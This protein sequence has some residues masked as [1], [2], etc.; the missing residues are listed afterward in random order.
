MKKIT[1]FLILTHIF[2]SPTYGGID[3]E[4]KEEGQEKIKTTTLKIKYQSN[5]KFVIQEGTRTYTTDSVQPSLDK[6]GY[7]INKNQNGKYILGVGNGLLSVHE[8]IKVDTTKRFYAPTSYIKMNFNL[9]ST[10]LENT[11]RDAEVGIFDPFSAKR[12]F[13]VQWKK[14]SIQSWALEFLCED[15][16]EIEVNNTPGSF[17]F[18]FDPKGDAETPFNQLTIKWKPNIS[19]TV[20]TIS[21]KDSII[22]AKGQEFAHSFT[23]DGIASGEFDKLRYLFDGQVIKT[24]KNGYEK[25]ISTLA[26]IDPY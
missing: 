1:T 2:C 25:P 18:K 20:S 17:L 11:V 7:L 3:I 22:T 4:E 15:A 16:E 26:F 8:R 9:P 14:S 23:L 6:E 24:F 21:L 12:T 19:S 5:Q 13:K 10:D